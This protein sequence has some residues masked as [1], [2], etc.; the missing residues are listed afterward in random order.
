MT[1][2][3]KQRCEAMKERILPEGERK[4]LLATY[5]EAIRPILTKLLDERAAQL[6]DGWDR[7]FKSMGEYLSADDREALSRRLLTHAEAAQMLG[8]SVATVK[9]MVQQGRLPQPVEISERRIG[10]RM[11]DIL[12][13]VGTNPKRGN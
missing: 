12:A 7:S 1:D 4:Q 8:C 5:G 9:R 11:P 2:W 13:F 10:H 6:V 3:H